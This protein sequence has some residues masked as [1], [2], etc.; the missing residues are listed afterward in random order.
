MYR[1]TY[2]IYYD[3]KNTTSLNATQPKHRRWP[4][5]GL[6]N[7]KPTLG[8][9]LMFVAETLS[10]CRFRADPGCKERVGIR[11]LGGLSQIFSWWI[12]FVLAIFLK[13]LLKQ[14]WGAVTIRP[15]VSTP[16]A[17]NNTLSPSHTQSH[18]KSD[19]P[20]SHVFR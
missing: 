8:R 9:R 18:I 20:G 14:R 16:S 4:N 7:G 12:S 1:H 6:T 11:G 19:Q 5:V 13:Y 2:R 3:Q 10:Q 17:A 15:S